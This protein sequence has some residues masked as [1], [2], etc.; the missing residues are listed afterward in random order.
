MSSDQHLEQMKLGIEEMERDIQ[1]LEHIER[2]AAEMEKNPND[3][4]FV[5]IGLVK[6]SVTIATRDPDPAVRP[7]MRRFLVQLL[8]Q[9][10]NPQ[11]DSETLQ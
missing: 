7:I 1:L 10:D 9:L 4:L 8:E 5:S 3:P 11:A 6:L 2:R